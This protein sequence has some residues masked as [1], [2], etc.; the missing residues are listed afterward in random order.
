[1]TR[2]CQGDMD[3][4][5]CKNRIIICNESQKLS[6]EIDLSPSGVIVLSFQEDKLGSSLSVQTVLIK[7]ARGKKGNTAISIMNL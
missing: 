2:W 6:L 7:A 1:M 5:Y 3:L 4:N